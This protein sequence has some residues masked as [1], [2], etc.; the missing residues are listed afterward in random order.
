MALKITFV[1]SGDAFGSGGRF[2]TCI[3]VE[4]PDICFAIDFGAS[5]LIALNALG[6]PHNKINLILLTHLH[7]DHC[8]GVSALLLDAMLGAK[9][10]T[11]LT[12]AGPC[13]TTARLPQIQEVLFPGSLAMTPKF[14]VK[15]IDMEVMTPY[16]ISGLGITTYPAIHTEATNPTSMRVEVADKVIAYTG[17]SAWTE[18]MPELA[19]GADLL[20]SECYFFKKRVPYHMNYPDLYDH[21]DELQAKRVVLTHLGPEMLQHRDEIPEECA[22][23]GLVIEL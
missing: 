5:S 21:R 10:E 22:Y 3:L 18:H 15:T 14:E 1:G 8:G 12:I 20:I 16:E 9:R 6:I 11:S 7:G 17:D 13:E 23:D 4:A 2:N 19:R